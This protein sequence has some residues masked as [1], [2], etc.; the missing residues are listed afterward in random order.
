M[1]L[2]VDINAYFASMLQQET[3]A[4]RGKP[5]GVIK[6]WGRSCII[7]ASKEAKLKGVKTGT[8]VVLARQQCPDLI[9]VKA[10]FDLFLSGTMKLQQLFSDVSPEVE[11]F[12]LDESFIPFAPLRN[13]YATPQALAIHMQQKV[14]EVL[15]EWVTCNI[16]IAK[17]R[18]IAKMAGETAPKGSIVSVAETEYQSLLST[19]TFADVC[20]IGYRL[21]ARLERLGV[22]VPYQINFLTN[23][24]L[25][26]QFGPFWSVELKKMALG[27]EPLF[28]AR[29]TTT[30]QQA[31]TISRSITLF[32]L[33]RD[34][35]AIRRVLYNLS[36]E[37]LY[38]ART[39]Q[40]AG[41]QVGVSLEGQSEYWARHTTLKQTLQHTSSF[42]TDV[43]K[44]VSTRASAFPV[45]RLRV[46]LSLLESTRSS[47][48]SLLPEWWASERL[49]HALDS[50]N[51]KYGLY[52]VRSGLLATDPVIKPE[53]TGFLG[54]KTYQLNTWAL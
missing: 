15:G 39:Q 2:H 26:R 18:F 17:T 20:G 53:V 27:K 11:V 4:L 6:D 40:L 51:N 37:V 16:G 41:R 13:L 31:K 30:N 49:E 33:A 36:T 50:I 35:E 47:Q 54:D 43:M 12:S 14:H 44:M 29:L 1:Y 21:G 22:T 24:V 52:T 34:E 46:Y 48:L 9:L 28:L 3:P 8:T 45:I 10:D 42:F 19:T 5:L 32:E 38:K 23:E 25:L 7:A